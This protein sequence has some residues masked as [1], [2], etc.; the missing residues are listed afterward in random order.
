VA[1]QALG[2]RACVVTADSPSLARSELREATELARRLGLRHQ[3]VATGELNDQRTSA[4]APTAAT[5][6]RTPSCA[7]AAIS[8]ATGCKKLLVGVNLDDLGDHRPGQRAVR[9]LG[10]RWPLVEVGLAKPEIRW[11]SKVL[12]L[13]TWDKPAAA[14]LSSRLAYGVP[15]TA[16]ALRRIEQAEESLRTLNLATR[17]CAC[18]TR[19]A[20]WPGWR[21]TPTASG[22]SCGIACGSSRPSRRPASATSRSTWRAPDSEATTPSWW[23][24]AL[25]AGGTPGYRFTSTAEAENQVVSDRTI[26]PASRTNARTPPTVRSCGGLVRDSRLIPANRMAAAARS[27]GPNGT[28]P[29]GCLAVD[30]I[31]AGRPFPTW[32]RQVGNSFPR[33]LRGS[34]R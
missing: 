6:A 15:V 21:R 2:Q 26:A 22:R 27:L 34:G 1:H 30:V 28:S 25:P 3:I 12:A 32:V 9:E 20:T 7:L 31:V 29:P 16:E 5:S 24:C 4:T 18:A 17:S 13:P 23:S 14:C 11:L 8:A 10:G 33:I 19:V